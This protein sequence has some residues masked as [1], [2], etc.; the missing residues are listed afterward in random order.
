MLLFFLN[1]GRN[2]KA[3]A[4]IGGVIFLIAFGWH[5]KRMKAKIKQQKKLIGGLRSKEITTEI[6]EK[7]RAEYH[8]ETKEI[9]DADEAEVARRLND[10]PW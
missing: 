5:F 9:K 7:A 2:I 3:V 4:I 10:L 6:V 8:K 1:L